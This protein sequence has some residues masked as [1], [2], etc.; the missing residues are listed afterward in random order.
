MTYTKKSAHIEYSV[1]A[2][3]TSGD[4]IIKGELAITGK[5]PRIVQY[6]NNLRIP[7]TYD[8]QTLETKIL[9]S[10]EPSS[11]SPYA[12]KTVGKPLS[13]QRQFFLEVIFR[14]VLPTLST[15]LRTATLFDKRGRKR[16]TKWHSALMVV[17][18]YAD[19]NSSYHLSG[20]V[21]IPPEELGIQETRQEGHHRSRY[22]K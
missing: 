4:T 18:F 16:F 1:L 15:Y 19:E 3:K 6:F 13:A 2:V 22:R 10:Y 7:F 17:D 8:D 5:S 12:T 20:E 9:E 11:L 21:T 14:Y